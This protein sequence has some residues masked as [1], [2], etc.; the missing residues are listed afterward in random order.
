MTVGVWEDIEMEIG[1]GFKPLIN[2]IQNSLKEG[3][4]YYNK[5]L[6]IYII[7]LYFILKKDINMQVYLW[8]QQW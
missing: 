4:C 5:I 1:I 6:K 7:V 8:I 3:N 2:K